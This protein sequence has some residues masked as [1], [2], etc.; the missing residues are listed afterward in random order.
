MP[1]G[2][3]PFRHLLALAQGTRAVA[4]GPPRAVVTPELLCA[5]Y[6]VDLRVAE[7]DGGPFVLAV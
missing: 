6:E 2:S 3:R 1:F 4:Q 5:V 7:V